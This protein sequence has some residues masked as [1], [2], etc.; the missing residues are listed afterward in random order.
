MP[1]DPRRIRFVA[2]RGDARLRLD[3]VLVRRV[4]DISRMSRSRAQQWISS[5]AVLVDGIAAIRP[6]QRVRGGA[7]IEIALPDTAAQR[8]RP[9]PEAIPLDILYEDAHL[10]A[11]NKPAG[12]VVHPSYRNTTGTLLNAV[13]W[14]VRH[15]QGLRPGIVSRL[16]KNTSGV[17]LVSLQP[18]VHAR[19]QRTGLRKEYLALVAG[20]PRPRA[21]LITLPL[22]RAS[23]DRRRVAVVETGTPAVTRYETV[24]SAGGVSLL[25]CE[26]VTG[27]T[28]QIRVHLAARGWPILGD[29]V[30]GRPHPGI[31]RPALHAWR[32]GFRHPVTG[33]ELELVAPIP[34]DMATLMRR[35]AGH[36]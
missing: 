18:E 16:D 12:L 7:R 24:A 5:G 31:E 22:G 2:D 35:R 29:P 27:R 34:G 33:T 17:L 25:R 4:T 36:A 26:L 32:V 20:A 14:H 11:V 6:S 23:G 28:H 3:R 9:A 15:D 1:K 8:V 30:Y 19:L 21:G 10:L 13:L